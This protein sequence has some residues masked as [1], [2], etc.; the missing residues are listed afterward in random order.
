MFSLKGSAL[1]TVTFFSIKTRSHFKDFNRGFSSLP[2]D[3]ESD[4]KVK[5]ITLEV[6]NIYYLKTST[7]VKQLQFQLDMGETNERQQHGS[8]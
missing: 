2:I 8:C 7:I 1:L 6:Y 5:F 3:Y 4:M